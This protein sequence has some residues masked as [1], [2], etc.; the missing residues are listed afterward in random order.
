MKKIFF[1]I[2]T[3]AAITFSACNGTA[4][5]GSETDSISAEAVQAT[6]AATEAIN[7][8]S[9]AIESASAEDTKTILTQAKEY[10]TKLQ[11]E[12]KIEEAK[13]YLVKVQQYIKDN[14]EKINE[15][16]KDNEAVS[17]IVSAIKAIPADALNAADA[18]AEDAETAAEDLKEAGSE[19]LEEAEEAAKAAEAETPAE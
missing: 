15:F 18:I 9:T 16:A 12:G 6:E 13:A 10:I 1:A 5:G 8:L 14:E 17:S 7:E 2:V 11:Q 3:I 19:A 4:Q